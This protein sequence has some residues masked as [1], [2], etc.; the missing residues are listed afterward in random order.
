MASGVVKPTIVSSTFCRSHR[1]KYI[2]SVPLCRR[3]IEYVVKEK[4]KEE[5]KEKG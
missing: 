4:E 3:P 5:E 1:A 2:L